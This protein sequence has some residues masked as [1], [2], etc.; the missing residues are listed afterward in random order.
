[1]QGNSYGYPG[2]YS[3]RIEIFY[4]PYTNSISSD[5]IYVGQVTCSF[6]WTVTTFVTRM[7]RAVAYFTF[8][9]VH[10]VAQASDRTTTVGALFNRAVYAMTVKLRFLDVTSS[11]PASGRFDLLGRIYDNTSCTVYSSSEYFR[12]EQ[13]TVSFLNGFNSVSDSYMYLGCFVFDSETFY[14]TYPASSRKQDCIQSCS[15]AGYPF[16]AYRSTT[17]TLTLPF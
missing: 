11:L 12:P 10:W 6:R 7:H 16:A 9:P 1:M 14:Q 5:F 15:N 3:G 8:V 4:S 17:G 2:I 13:L